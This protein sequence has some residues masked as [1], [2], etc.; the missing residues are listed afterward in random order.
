MPLA[1]SLSSTTTVVCFGRNCILLLLLQEQAL[2]VEVYINT[3]IHENN[4]G[5]IV[6]LLSVLNFLE[7]FSTYRLSPVVKT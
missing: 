7:K 4:M 2:T 5:I 1:V 3:T 6:D